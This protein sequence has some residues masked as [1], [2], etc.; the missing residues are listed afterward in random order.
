V[1][2]VAAGAAGTMWSMRLPYVPVLPV[3]TERVVLREFRPDDFDALL[4]FHSDPD[5]VLYVPFAPRTPEE[6]RTALGK[7]IAGTSLAAAGDHLDLA[8][9]LHDGTV[10]GDLVVMLHEVEHGTVEVGWIFDPAHSGHGYATEA[11]RAMFDLVFG[12]LQA[13]R[14]VARVDARN[15]ASLRLCERIGMRQEAHLVENEVFKGGLSSEIDFALLS[16]EWPAG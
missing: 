10:V 16:R 15:T 7:K 3:R 12:G 4:P 13:R 8:V 9:A 14:A 2:P 5:N 6:M 11:V 1:A